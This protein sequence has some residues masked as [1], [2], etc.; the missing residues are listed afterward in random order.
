[1]SWRGGRSRAWPGL[2][3]CAASVWLAVLDD[4]AELVLSLI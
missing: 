2:G 4:A 3:C 1:M